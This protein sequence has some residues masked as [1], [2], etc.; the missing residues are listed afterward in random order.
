[1]IKKVDV[2]AAVIRENGKILIAQRPNESHLGGQW[3]FP[4]GK[5]ETGETQHEAL[6]R[7]IKEEL[8]VDIKPVKLLGE[9]E[10]TYPERHVHLFF[11][12]A[13]IVSGQIKAV[14]H[15]DIRWVKPETMLNYDLAKG[16]IGFIKEF[17]I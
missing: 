7:E 1:M 8:T 9:A 11:Y 12:D 10:H 16:D 2:V 4:G 14:E 3:E 6:I 17:L 5:I 13:E 15:Q